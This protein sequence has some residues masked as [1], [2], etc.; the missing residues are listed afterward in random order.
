MKRVLVLAS[1]ACMSPALAKP[2]PT[3][4]EFLGF[5]VGADRQLADYRQIVSYF[6]QLAADSNRVRLQNLGPTT[7]GSEMILAVIS[8]E[9][10]LKQLQKYKD[11][12]R[13]IADPRGLTPA[14]VDSL[15]E[16][17]KVIVL[18]TCNIHSTEI[19]SS[20]MA[21]EWAHALATANDPDTRRRLDQVI[22]LLMPSLNPD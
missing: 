12:A 3:P 8:S 5:R 4:S 6:K 22:L 15:V 13:Q 18:V 7:L 2:P 11:I 19:G 10:N 17:G 21:L 1:L 9:E 14:Q 16:Q 20:Q